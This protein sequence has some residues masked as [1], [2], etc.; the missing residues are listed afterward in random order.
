MLGLEIAMAA[1]VAVY[2]LWPAG[3]D[4]VTGYAAWLHSGGILA[5]ALAAALAG[6]VLSELSLV[7]VQ[8]GGRWTR[9]H[10]ERM[11]FNSVLFFLG[12]SVVYE[13]YHLQACLFGDSP[14]WRVILKKLVVDQF[15]FTVFWATPYQALVIRWQALHYSASRLRGELGWNFVLER[16]VPILLTN[17]IFWFPC[18]GLIYSM[19]LLLQPALFIF[20]T[21]SWGLLMPAVARQEREGMVAP[22]PILSGS[23]VLPTE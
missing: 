9:V 15:G 20:G 13:F 19:P 17:W 2:Y 11:L 12:G 22:A 14:D 6:G 5:T 23:E 1:V 3:A 21:A 8:H 10:L 7:Y 18:M 16:M 4:V